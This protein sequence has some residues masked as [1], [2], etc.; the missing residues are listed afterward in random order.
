MTQPIRS[1]QLPPPF[2]RRH[3]QISQIET[4]APLELSGSKPRMGIGVARPHTIGAPMGD[5]VRQAD[6]RPDAASDASEGPE[7]RCTPRFTLLIRAAKLISPAGEFLCVVRDASETG[8]SVRLFHPLPGDVPLS[9]EMPNGDCLALER[10]W[11]DE[12]KAGFRFAGQVE[13]ERIVDCPS[14]FSRRAV[15]VNVEVP[16]DLLVGVRRV[17]GTIHNLSQQGAL[18]AT[19]E[20]L[21]LMQRVKIRADGMPEITGKVRWRRNDNYG[22]SF[23]DTFQFAELAALAFEL[24][25][26]V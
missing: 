11:E 19:P 10:V 22:L 4:I 24:R 15:R 9:L 23:E 12:G 5:F 25:R 16:C 14:R 21:S 26:A 13:I 2:R 17:P 18:I 7:Q 1:A 20:R 8:V 6:I 3:P